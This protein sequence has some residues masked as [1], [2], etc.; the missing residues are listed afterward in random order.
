MNCK[1]SR[2]KLFRSIDIIRFLS[3][4]RYN[5]LLLG[6]FTTGTTY[7]RTATSVSRRLL[8][9]NHTIRVKWKPYKCF[10]CKYI[11]IAELGIKSAGSLL[12]PPQLSPHC[13]YRQSQP[14]HPITNPH[15]LCQHSPKRSRK[16]SRICELS[17]T[18]T[19]DVEIAA[20]NR[21]CVYCAKN[22]FK[23]RGAREPMMDREPFPLIPKS[24][25]THPNPPPNKSCLQFW[26]TIT[27]I[28]IYK[29][30][31]PPSL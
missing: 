27:T 20:M 15:T 5:G 31:E 11:Y 26:I 4:I 3:Q 29:I 18:K 21:K 12:H 25:L 10:L 1:Y 17:I 30:T 22:N 8:C 16:S 14:T 28:R 19:D 24:K 9:T 2:L 6:T 7:I 23:L 13:R